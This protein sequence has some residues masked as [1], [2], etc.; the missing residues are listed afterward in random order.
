MAAGVPVADFSSDVV[1]VCAETMVQFTDLTTNTPTG[2][3]WTFE[4]GTP[5]TRALQH[6]LVMFADGGVYECN[7]EQREDEAERDAG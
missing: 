1:V 3:A 6:P 2:W 4:G 7:S 5:A